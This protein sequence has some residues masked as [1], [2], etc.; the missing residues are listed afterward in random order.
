[1]SSNES[2]VPDSTTST[3]PETP[4]LESIGKNVAIDKLTLELLMNKR[5]YRKYVEK[6]NP[7]EYT[8]KQTEYDRFLKYKPR[9]SHLIHELLNDYSVSGN[10]EHLGNLDIQDSFQSLL[11][12]CI[13][14]FETRDYDNRESHYGGQEDDTIFSPEHMNSDS[15]KYSGGEAGGIRGNSRERSLSEFTRNPTPT[16][17]AVF[18]APFAN[19]YRPG[20]SFWGKNVSKHG[21][22][23]R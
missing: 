19:H 12:S 9:I 4:E 16:D 8:K 2:E 18:S 3:T 1:M 20:N 23:Q 6:H 13:Y 11:N 21:T 15:M 17:S 14:F 7:E 10:S 5:Q 22:T